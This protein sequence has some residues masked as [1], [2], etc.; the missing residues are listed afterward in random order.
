M[1]YLPRFILW[2]FFFFCAQFFS[3]T[4]IQKKPKSDNENVCDQTRNSPNPQMRF[5][6]RGINQEFLSRQAVLCPAVNCLFLIWW[7]SEADPGF[8][9]S[10][11]W[12]TTA[13]NSTAGGSVFHQK[14]PV[15]KYN[16]MHYIDISTRKV[17]CMHPACK[18]VKAP[19]LT[20][21]EI[22]CKRYPTILTPLIWITKKWQ[23]QLLLD[24]PAWKGPCTR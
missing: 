18:R 5:R 12:F 21:S 8:N 20:H 9:F 3:N 24:A 14:V 11:E 15:H 1:C 13:C 17:G 6:E 10:L 16:H 2:F 23:L 19:C 7:L 4:K 22:S